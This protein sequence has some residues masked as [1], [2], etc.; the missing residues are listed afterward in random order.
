M[1]K[2]LSFVLAL[3]M[4][5]GCASIAMAT[6]EPA[7][8]EDAA[9]I[10]PAAGP[11]DEAVK[12]LEEHGILK[13]RDNY[14]LALESPIKRYEMA[15]FVSRLLTGWIDDSVWKEDYNKDY[16]A[17]DDLDGSGAVNYYGAIRYA[18]EKG[19]IQGYGDKK[20]GPEDGIIYKDALTMMCRAL[21]YG[22]LSYPWGYI[23]TAI[24][25][26]LTAGIE[27]VA[28]TQELVRGEVAQII[29]NALFIPTKNGDTLASRIWGVDISWQ[30]AVITASAKA[31]LGIG[32][33]TDADNKP[34]APAGDGKVAF[35]LIDTATGKLNAEEYVVSIKNKLEDGRYAFDLDSDKAANSAIGTP[36]KVLLTSKDGYIQ[37]L[38]WKKLPS[39]TIWNEGCLK[40][41]KIQTYLANYA[42]VSVFGAK[43]TYLHTVG[44]D[45]EM[46]LRSALPSDVTYTTKEVKAYAL[47]WTNGDILK[48]TGIKDDKTDTTTTTVGGASLADTIYTA[49]GKDTP[50]TNFIYEVEWIYNAAFDLYF[51]WEID[52]TTGKILGVNT[53]KP[54]DIEKL[55]GATY[56]YEKKT[57]TKKLAILTA[58]PGKTAY[59][60]LELYDITG[61]GVN[62]WG[63]YEE[64]GIGKVTVDGGKY[65]VAQPYS[66]NANRY[67]AITGEEFKPVTTEKT[68]YLTLI[69]DIQ[70]GIAAP[71]NGDYVIYNFNAQ[72][73]ELKIVKDIDQIND[74][75]NY[76]GRGVVRAYDVAKGKVVISSAHTAYVAENTDT[77]LVFDYAD[78]KWNKLV[79][80]SSKTS[81]DAYVL[82]DYFGD[83]FNQYVEYVVCDGKLVDIYPINDSGVKLIA[84]DA[85]A[86]VSDDGTVVVLG[87]NAYTG[88]YGFYRVG[89]Y[90]GWGTGDFFYYGTGAASFFGGFGFG[91]FRTGAPLL[92]VVSYDKNTDTYYVEG[93][94]WN[95]NPDACLVEYEGPNVKS[96][97]DEDGNKHGIRMKSTDKYVIVNMRP[98]IDEPVVIMYEGKLKAGW[99][100]CGENDGDIWFVSDSSMFNGFGKDKVNVEYVLFES[101]DNKAA[102]Y[103]TWQKGT[104]VDT[105]WYLLGASTKLAICRNALNPSA[106]G[107]YMV[108]NTNLRPGTI[109]VARDGFIIGESACDDLG[110]LIAYVASFNFSDSNETLYGEDDNFIKDYLTAKDAAGR[111]LFSKKVISY[112]KTMRTKYRNAYDSTDVHEYDNLITGDTP[113]VYFV[114]GFTMTKL[115]ADKF[116]EVTKGASKVPFYYIFTEGGE[117]FC[118]ILKSQLEFESTKDYALD[119]GDF[120]D[121][122]T[123]TVTETQ[124]ASEHSWE[125]TDAAFGDEA[126]DSITDNGDETWTIVGKDGSEATVYMCSSHGPEC[127][128]APIEA[129]NDW[130]LKVTFDAINLMDGDEIAAEL[131]VAATFDKMGIVGAPT[132]SLLIYN[133]STQSV[134]VQ[135]PK[136]E[137]TE[138]YIWYYKDI[139][140]NEPDESET[141]V[142]PTA[143]G[144]DWDID[145]SRTVDG[146]D[147]P[148]SYTVSVTADGVEDV[149][150]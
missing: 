30:T 7:I 50:F 59:A 90:N 114:D 26:G 19:I 135:E 66:V 28:W 56:A 113:T 36:Y 147:T 141:E 116:A 127:T 14:D 78:L 49:I 64:Y 129:E 93:Y 76:R 115:N 149:T 44:E 9:L 98:T 47:D 43:N 25:L 128:S 94:E 124:N 95:F 42:L 121:A 20:F 2:I 148:Y 52:T 67:K 143:N 137:V 83:I 17:F 86:G 81:A 142:T 140:T 23:E 24:N 29:Y 55:I 150:P 79:A 146:T 111:K 41:Y 48:I 33:G 21:G 126:A 117:C 106:V 8:S 53:L 101:W 131:T 71:A 35:K 80:P 68:D 3:L 58:K 139:V 110:E 120:E 92:K 82:Y 74:E 134:L 109:Y 6:D 15:I 103:D 118:Y 100:I 87:Y 13:G 136:P 72:T 144:A 32:D 145:F 18:E 12:F 45:T 70:P 63:L 108:V 62:D 54:E 31:T 96:F 40:E 73:K 122:L 75:Y 119:L 16:S 88:K 105:S 123:V 130:T 138:G 4:T 69:D 107:E 65:T 5:I 102:G 34:V 51:Q 10:A 77:T 91:P 84:V 132:A 11:Y 112:N 39:E 61:D 99:Y 133:Q 125:I 89:S 57:E 46:I 22:G 38:D 1:K 37:L 104:T 85:Y 97:T 27:N 60:S